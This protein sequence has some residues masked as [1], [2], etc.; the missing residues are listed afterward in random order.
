MRRFLLF[1][2]ICVFSLSL[3]FS[4]AGKTLYVAVENAPVKDSAGNFSSERGK[5]P[6]GTMVTAVSEKGK[7]TEIRAG[8]LTG[9]V[10]S[11]DLSA[12]RVIASGSTVTPGEV[13][14]AGKGFSPQ[15]E[16]EYR[17][18]GLD[19]SRVDSMERIAIPGTELQRFIIDG[20]LA[21]GEQ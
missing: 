20:R 8:N 1:F 21:G 11:A 7:W 12:R 6:L 13:A 14:L 19:Y 15:M 9:W 5:L 10:A 17:R 18:G 2:M 4:Q 16:T 3:A